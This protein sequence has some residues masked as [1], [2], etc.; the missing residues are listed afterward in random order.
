MSSASS[1]QNVSSEQKCLALNIY[2]EAR[3]SDIADQAAVSDVVLNRVK[4]P[5][6]PNTVCGVIYQGNY[7]ADGNIMRNQC[8]FSW[9][10]DGK[11]DVPQDPVSWLNADALA[12]QILN[13]GDFVGITQGSTHYHADYIPSPSWAITMTP[14]AKIGGH[15]FYRWE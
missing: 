5:R 1:A 6:Y 3:G 13:S 15:Y 8:Q 11:S 4:D 12:S 10:C 2:Y 9:Y 14:V 7:D